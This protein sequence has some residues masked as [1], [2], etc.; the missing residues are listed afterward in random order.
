[1]IAE[2]SAVPRVASERC[3]GRRRRT[4]GEGVAEPRTFRRPGVRQLKEGATENIFHGD[5]ELNQLFLFPGKRQLLIAIAQ[6][7]VEISKLA[8]EGLRFQL[9][10]IHPRQSR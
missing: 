3:I 10:R 9:T 7:N 2:Q 6:R 5:L 8:L 4:N 1:G